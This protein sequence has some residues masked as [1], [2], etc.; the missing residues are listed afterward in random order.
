MGFLNRIAEK[1]AKSEG[2]ERLAADRGLSYETIGTL[3]EVTP[4]LRAAQAKS[5]SSVMRGRLGGRIQGYAAMMTHSVPDEGFDEDEIDTTFHQVVL[6]GA[7][8]AAAF[9]P[10]LVVASYSG[11]QPLARER[12]REIA[13]ESIEVGR[14]YRIW[15]GSETSENRVRQL[16]SPVMVDWLAGVE[17]GGFAF[18]LDRGWFGAYSAPSIYVPFVQPGKPEELAWLMDTADDLVGQILSEA[19]ESA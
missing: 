7:P 5:F 1:A 16:L 6:A 11:W 4:L 13:T 10:T 14:R 3:P 15:I 12:L 8:D 19:S 2:H 9:I 17:V 18:E